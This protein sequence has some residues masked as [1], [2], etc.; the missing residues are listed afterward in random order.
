VVVEQVVDEGQHLAEGGTAIGEGE[1]ALAVLPCQRR[2]VD[3]LAE[4]VADDDVDGLA[5]AAASA[6]NFSKF[7][8]LKSG[9]LSR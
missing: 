6:A 3:L 7:A 5:W 1:P 8:T 4:A 2:R 9:R